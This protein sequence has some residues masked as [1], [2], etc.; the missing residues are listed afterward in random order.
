[1]SEAECF[2]CLKATDFD[3]TSE[4]SL[5]YIPNKQYCCYECLETFVPSLDLYCSEDW[6][7]YVLAEKT[8]SYGEVL[9]RR[10]FSNRTKAE[11]W[12]RIYMDDAK[13]NKENDRCHGSNKGVEV[14][15]VWYFSFTED[16]SFSWNKESLDQWVKDGDLHGETRDDVEWEDLQNG[17]WKI[18]DDRDQIAH[19]IDRICSKEMVF[20]MSD[21]VIQKR[22][23]QLDNEICRLQRKKE[24]FLIQTSKYLNECMN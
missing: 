22:I 2:I 9:E 24:K 16:H 12:M 17:K 23:S 6:N 7:F 19:Y 14:D 4:V 10:W 18:G 20:Q 13:E 21:K 8:R 11:N 15:I 1:M 5:K 3:Q